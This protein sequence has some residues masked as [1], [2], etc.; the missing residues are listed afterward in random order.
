MNR[1]LV[2][3]AVLGLSITGCAVAIDDPVPAP[4]EQQPQKA[5]PQQALNGDLQD[6]VTVEDLSRAD[7]P[8][9]VA[10]RQRVP[11]LPPNM[12]EEPGE[13]PEQ[14]FELPAQH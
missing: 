3:A 1:L 4:P 12:A 8:P 11:G 9:S 2:V 7:A 5:P 6:P 10:P 13:L 14:A